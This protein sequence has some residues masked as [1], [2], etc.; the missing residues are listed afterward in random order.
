MTTKNKPANTNRTR[1]KAKA[2]ARRK[3]SDAVD[4]LAE[5][6]VLPAAIKPRHFTVA[7]IRNAVKLAIT[8]K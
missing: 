5:R 1:L 8:S 6:V 7:A 3:L 2:I 4:N